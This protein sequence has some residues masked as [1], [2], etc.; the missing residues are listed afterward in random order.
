MRLAVRAL[1]ASP[2]LFHMRLLSDTTRIHLPSLPSRCSGR[3]SRPRTFAYPPLSREPGTCESPARSGYILLVGKM[4][5]PGVCGLF[6]DENRAGNPYTQK[7]CPMDAESRPV[8]C[9]TLLPV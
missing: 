6:V 8:I 2:S 5:P 7:P 9:G 3:A 4:L 1:S